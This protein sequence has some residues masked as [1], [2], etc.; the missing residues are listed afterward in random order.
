M[1]SFAAKFFEKVEK[2]RIV[3]RVLFLKGVGVGEVKGME[4]P[5]LEGKEK[6]E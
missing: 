6:S 1:P 4:V 5:L 3:R 2:S